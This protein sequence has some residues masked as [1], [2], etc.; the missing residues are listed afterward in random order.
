MSRNK[1]KPTKFI[2][3]DR[4]PEYLKEKL[5]GSEKITE[6][7]VEFAFQVASGENYLTAYKNIYNLKEGTPTSNI[8]SIARQLLVKP[9]VQNIIKIIKEEI[10]QQVIVDINT[11]IGRLEELFYEAEMEDSFDKKLKVLKEMGKLVVSVNGT[12]NIT[13]NTIKFQLPTEIKKESRTIQLE[14][15]EEKTIT[16]I[17]KESIIRRILRENGE[18]DA[19][20]ES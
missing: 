19:E 3:L 14:N 15:G 7:M 4:I 2:H 17:S 8:R 11:V 16:N 6:Q 5:G 20:M 18:E 9:Q 1:D 12:I 10:K 13:S